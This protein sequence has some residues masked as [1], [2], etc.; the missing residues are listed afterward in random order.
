MFITRFAWFGREAAD[1]DPSFPSGWTDAFAIGFF[2][3]AVVVRAA[4][5]VACVVA[6]VRARP[7]AAWPEE[8][9]PERLATGEQPR[10]RPAVLA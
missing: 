2:E 4:I 9:P 6:W 1:R 5:M 7:E 3:F 8:P 10:G